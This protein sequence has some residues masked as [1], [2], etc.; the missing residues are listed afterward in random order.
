[1]IQQV[2]QERGLSIL[3]SQADAGIV[4]ADPGLDVTAEV[5]R[6]FDSS[7]PH[8]Q[9]SNADPESDDD[10]HATCDAGSEAG[11]DREAAV[12]DT[13]THAEAAE[14][15]RPAAWRPER[16]PHARGPGPSGPGLCQAPLLVYHPGRPCPRRAG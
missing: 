12:A 1:M 5:I 3:F 10:G 16:C 13:D 9:A 4:W 14:T 2:V 15:V 7:A 6:R 11:L 8:P